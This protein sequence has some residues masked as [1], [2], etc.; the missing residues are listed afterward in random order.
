MISC[1]DTDPSRYTVFADGVPVIIVAFQWAPSMATG[2]LHIRDW[3]RGTQAACGV[4][5]LSA[6][7]A[8][9]GSGVDRCRKCIVVRARM[10]RAVGRAADRLAGSSAMPL[11]SVPAPL[12]HPPSEG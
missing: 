2:R 3:A 12:Y 6:F 11:P 7:D 9:C 8:L 10:I 1:S 4:L 5:R